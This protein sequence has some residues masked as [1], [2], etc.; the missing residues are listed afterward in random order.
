MLISDRKPAAGEELHDGQM[1]QQEPKRNNGHQLPTSQ[2]FANP[3]QDTAPSHLFQQVGG[4]LEGNV[5]NLG[6]RGR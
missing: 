3:A 2:G 5:F 6:D 4:V 1:K